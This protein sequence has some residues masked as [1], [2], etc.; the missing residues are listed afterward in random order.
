MGGLKCILKLC[1]IGRRIWIL[2][3]KPWASRRPFRAKR[4]A[5][6]EGGSP[7]SPSLHLPRPHLSLPVHQSCPPIPSRLPPP[8]HSHHLFLLLSPTSTSLISA[9]LYPF[10]DR[11]PRRYRTKVIFPHLHIQYIDFDYDISSK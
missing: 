1:V 3:L 6:V 11:L 2:L 7:V 10:F 8:L 9:S 5:D 4:N